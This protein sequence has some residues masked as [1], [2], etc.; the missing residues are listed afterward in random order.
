MNP[1]RLVH[2]GSGPKR[3]QLDVLMNP[4]RHSLCRSAVRSAVIIGTTRAR[5]AEPQAG[6]H[7]AHQA[8]AATQPDVLG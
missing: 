8:T 4:L 1:T 6:P 2:L 3:H 5:F 7:V